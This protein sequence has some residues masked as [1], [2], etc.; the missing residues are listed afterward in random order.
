MG[1]EVGKHESNHNVHLNLLQCEPA[2]E[3]KVARAEDGQPKRVSNLS[4]DSGSI[5]R[6]V[7]K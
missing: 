3:S 5:T 6:K 4:L 1:S 2:E 7:E